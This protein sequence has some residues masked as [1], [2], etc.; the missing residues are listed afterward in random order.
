MVWMFC[1]SEDTCAGCVF[2]FL[3]GEMGWGRGGF[4]MRAWLMLMDGIERRTR[5]AVQD[6]LL[7]KGRSSGIFRGSNKVARLCDR[8]VHHSPISTSFAASKMPSL[9]RLSLSSQDSPTWQH[10]Q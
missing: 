3:L 8:Y 6:V 5:S 2:V 7:P 4:G 10:P 9:Y 1:G